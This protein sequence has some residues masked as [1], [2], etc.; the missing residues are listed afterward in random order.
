MDVSATEDGLLLYGRGVVGDMQL[1]WLDRN[2]K[3]EGVV[4]D[5]LMYA[6]A[7]ISPQGDRV[8]VQTDSGAGTEDIYVLD[9]V[10]G[11]RS[12]LTFGPLT[13][14]SPHWS[15]DGK[16]IYYAS[17]RD[18]RY[19]LFRKLADGSSAEESIFASDQNVFPTDCSPDGK[20]LLIRQA[21]ANKSS[22]WALPLAEP[23]KPSQIVED[24]ADASF[25]PDGRYVVY[26][27]NQSGSWQVYVVPFGDRKGKWQV[28]PDMG[29][30]PLWS[31]D[32]K[33]LYY[34]TPSNSFS[35]I[36]VPVKEQGEGLQFGAAQ[37]LVSKM[38]SANRYNDVSSDGKRILVSRLSQRG[39]QSV[40]LVT[41]FTEGLKK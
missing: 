34:V 41:N 38:G 1:V 16:W 25:S 37:T 21:S 4:A 19:S 11:V 18:G 26:D 22:I 8:A 3:D 35:L 27:S 24:G 17:L 2:G 29:S 39:N 5:N 14:E 40:M 13:N 9:L 12:R 28:S 36:S 23:R 10:R 20:T 31:R 7:Q 32:G 15:H 33:E 30:G 6:R